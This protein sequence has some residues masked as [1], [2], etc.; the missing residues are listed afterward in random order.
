MILIV[1]LIVLCI[2]KLYFNNIN[3]KTL[4]NN[5]KIICIDNFITNYEINN[6]LKTGIP[7]LKDSVIVNEK[8]KHIKS[9]NRTSLSCFFYKNENSIVK[10]IEKK[11]SILSGLPIENIEPLQ[12]LK[13]NKNGKYKFHYDFFNPDKE[14]KYINGQRKTTIL[15]YLNEPKN[16]GETYFPKLNLKI[17]PKKYRAIMW[18][19]CT[20]DGKTDKRTLHSGEPLKKGV[21]YALNIWIRDKK[22]L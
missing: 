15:V 8:G 9:D 18:N 13:Y 14:G 3:K 11:A 17:K 5:P 21:K 10:N 4:C 20:K 12:L 7:R 19:N 1:L 22:Y 16:G 2:Y 6:L